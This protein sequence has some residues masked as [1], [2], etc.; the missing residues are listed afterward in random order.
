MGGFMFAK[1]GRV[2]SVS[3]TPETLFHQVN[4]Y[5]KNN[6]NSLISRCNA[7]DN[8]I[9]I[10]CNK[11]QSAISD[12]AKNINTVVNRA[13]TQ[14]SKILN[15]EQ[16]T[17]K[18]ISDL[19]NEVCRAKKIEEEQL[20]KIIENEDSIKTII[21]N[22]QDE[23]KNLTNSVQMLTQ[24]NKLLSDE[25]VKITKYLEESSL[26]Y[27][28]VIYMLLMKIKEINGDLGGDNMDE[29]IKALLA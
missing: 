10:E 4:T 27:K 11:N 14:D 20:K 1:R 24:Q 7:L 17:Q 6:I 16:K 21:K 9:N 23:I 22:H 25:N 15:L 13:N 5:A 26:A 2:E 28:K 29:N 8:K 3:P 12:V 18:C 19:Q